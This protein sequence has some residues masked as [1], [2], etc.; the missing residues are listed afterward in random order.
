MKLEV[1]EEKILNYENMDIKRLEN[2]IMI[3]NYKGYDKKTKELMK[4]FDKRVK[5]R[6]NPEMDKKRKVKMLSKY[7]KGG[8]IR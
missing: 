5:K 7:N 2:I 4:L 6:Y 1:F 8:I 3:L